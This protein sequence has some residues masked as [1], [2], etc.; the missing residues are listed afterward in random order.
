MR[1]RHLNIKPSR[2]GSLSRLFECIDACLE[3]G[4]ELYGGG[5]FELG[6]GRGQI[7]E[8]ASLFYPGTPNDV[9]PPAYNAP[10][11]VAGLPQSPLRPRPRAAAAA[12]AGEP[13]N[14]SGRDA[15]RAPRPATGLAADGELGR[16]LVVAPA[17]APQHEARGEQSATD[18]DEEEHVS[19]CERQVVRHAR[20]RR[21]GRS[22]A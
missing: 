22:S 13:E 4:I 6:V 3:R 18:T 1:V 12:S 10:E 8:I 9:A 20:R 7:Q 15:P 5:Q 16:S 2:F 17:K 21:R 14:S 11:P 19:A